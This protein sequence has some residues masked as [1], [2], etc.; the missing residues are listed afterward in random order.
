MPTQCTNINAL[1]WTGLGLLAA[2]LVACSGSDDP[3]TGT[4]KL[5]M[6]DA[7]GLRV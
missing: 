5:A 3:P 6:T 2:G 7:P 1:T 4:L